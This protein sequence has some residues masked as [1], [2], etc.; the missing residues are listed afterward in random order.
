MGEHGLHF[1]EVHI[2]TALPR[3]ETELRIHDVGDGLPS[4]VF[5]V[6]RSSRRWNHSLV[7]GSCV[8]PIVDNLPNRLSV[9]SREEMGPNVRK[10]PQF[11]ARAHFVYNVILLLF[12][13]P[14]LIFTLLL[15]TKLEFFPHLHLVLVFLP[16]LIMDG[17]FVV[18]TS[19]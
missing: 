15:V 12:G 6:P 1:C 8:S 7:L 4:P 3:A 16:L 14:T 2:R 5:R 10:L 13:I 18:A 9:G 17:M 11:H 19:R